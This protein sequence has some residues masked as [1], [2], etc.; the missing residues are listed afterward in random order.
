MNAAPEIGRRLG[1]TGKWS[2]VVFTAAVHYKVATPLAQLDL[3]MAA[4]EFIA[5]APP[6]STVLVNC[7]RGRSRSVALVIF[8]LMRTRRLSLRDAYV[9]VKTKRPFAGPS[10]HLQPQLQAMEMHLHGCQQST[11]DGASQAG[12]K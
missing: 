1:G 12:L 7:A 10:R 5:S 2:P 6:G 3:F 11:L 4:S 9:L 8:H